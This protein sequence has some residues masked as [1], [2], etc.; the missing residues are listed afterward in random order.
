MNN[1][2]QLLSVPKE[3]SAKKTANHIPEIYTFK[4]SIA[5][6]EWL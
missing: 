6:S 2:F 5:K 4:K 3:L 1:K